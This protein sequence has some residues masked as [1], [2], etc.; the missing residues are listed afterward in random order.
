[1]TISTVSSKY[2]IVIPKELRKQLHIRPGQKVLFKLNKKQQLIIETPQAAVAE[3]QRRFGG[4]KIWGDDPVA[5]IRKQRDEW[6]KD[7]SQLDTPQ[8]EGSSRQ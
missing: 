4:R 6:E 3:L 5:Y 1:M 8:N 7:Q 2:Q